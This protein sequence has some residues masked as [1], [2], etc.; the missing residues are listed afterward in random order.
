MNMEN[1]EIE[2]F[3]RTIVGDE[4]LTCIF[5][6]PI[7]EMFEIDRE[8]QRKFIQNDP[9][10]SRSTLK[11][12]A[13]SIFG[14][15]YNRLALSK[16]GF[17]RWIQLLNP[18]IVK[19]ELKE[20]LISYQIAIFDY[21]SGETLIPNTKERHTLQL[22]LKEI[23]SQIS[24]LLTE[25]KQVENEIRNIDNRSYGQIG[26]EPIVDEN[27]KLKLVSTFKK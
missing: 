8:N 25:K 6:H 3:K 20:Q 4:N 26:L 12:T 1:N 5:I 14:D 19:P 16:N 10:L 11:K 21:L 13:E 17:L 18:N 7:C 15:K 22:R 9:I 23:N 27:G 24:A 2:I